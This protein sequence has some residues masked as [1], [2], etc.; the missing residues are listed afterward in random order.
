MS[1]KS[2]HPKD[3]QLTEVQLYRLTPTELRRLKEAADAMEMPS[4]TLV[5]RCLGQMM[6]A[7]FENDF[8]RLRDLKI[9]LSASVSDEDRS[10]RLHRA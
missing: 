8:P 9:T 4:A 6:D 5:R 2:A 3:E 7:L 1:A 10:S